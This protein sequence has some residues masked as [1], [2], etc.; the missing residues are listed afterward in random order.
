[1][2]LRMRTIAAYGLCMLAGGLAGSFYD[3]GVTALLLLAYTAGAMV[4]AS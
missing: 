4:E 2:E 3:A 1:M